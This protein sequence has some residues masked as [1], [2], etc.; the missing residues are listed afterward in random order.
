MKPPRAKDRKGRELVLLKD[1]VPKRDPMGGG[2]AKPVFGEGSVLPRTD[3]PGP[4]RK[5]SGKK[6]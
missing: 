6:K 1:L 3:A 5:G 4:V 2:A